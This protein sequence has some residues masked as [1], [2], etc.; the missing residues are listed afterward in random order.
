MVHATFY[1]FGDQ[2]Y[3]AISKAPNSVG[4]FFAK[5]PVRTR[6]GTFSITIPSPVQDTPELAA[7]AATTLLDARAAC[8]GVELDPRA[9]R[10]LSAD[11]PP[12]ERE[13]NSS[14]CLQYAW[15]GRGLERG[16]SADT[17]RAAAP[18]PQRRRG[19]NVDIPWRR[20]A[21]QPRR[22]YSAETSRAAMSR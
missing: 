13:P 6:T 14:W 7:A 9:N 3:F 10:G 22:G 12:A 5:V 1:Y 16:Y 8:M 19:H 15:S 20:V 17:S 21:R 18:R 4:K 11:L 2:A